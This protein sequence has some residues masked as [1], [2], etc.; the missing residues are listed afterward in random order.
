MGI[1][2]DETKQPIL[3]KL[4][5]DLEKESNEKKSY[6]D[7][8]NDLSQKDIDELSKPYLFYD[9]KSSNLTKHKATCISNRKK[10]KKK[11]K[12]KY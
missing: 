9:N 5:E 2:E 10:R 11:R 3:Q 12:N 8:T 7:F 4:L 6:F 1:G